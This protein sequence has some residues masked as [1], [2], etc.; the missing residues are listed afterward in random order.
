MPSSKT[1][2]K[3]LKGTASNVVANKPSSKTFSIPFFNKTS[4]SNKAPVLP[5][6]THFI[7]DLSRLKES[8]MQ[9]RLVAPVAGGRRTHKKRTH[10]KRAL[11]K[12]T[13]RNK[14]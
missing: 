12:R 3:N 6:S 7:P 4:S 1:L 9:R 11:K 8:T 10:K 13:R 2:F 5:P 14:F